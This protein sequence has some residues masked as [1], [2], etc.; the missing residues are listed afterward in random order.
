M[1]TNQII[2][3]AYMAAGVFVA[4]IVGLASGDF[5][6]G[7]IT[8]LLII[9]GGAL[10]HEFNVRR[11]GFGKVLRGI[12]GLRETVDRADGAVTRMKTDFDKTVADAR[13][14]REALTQLQALH[15]AT[16]DQINA[17]KEQMGQGGGEVVGQMQ[18]AMQQ[19]HAQQQ[20]TSEDIGVIQTAGN[21]KSVV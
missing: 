21:R 8:G 3:I 6:Q 11:E 9:L 17:L 12:I 2:I 20:Q 13:T 18:E 10:G 15:T 19:L 5:F 1:G 14:A 7:L 16:E 4:G